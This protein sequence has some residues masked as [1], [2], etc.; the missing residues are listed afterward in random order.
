MRVAPEIFNVAVGGALFEGDKTN[1]K[2]L[3]AS[4]VESVSSSCVSS[5]IHRS[6]EAEHLVSESELNRLESGKVGR[7]DLR[8]YPKSHE[9]YDL[10]K[11]SVAPDVKPKPSEKAAKKYN[12]LTVGL[13]DKVNVESRLEL[14]RTS[15][16]LGGVP[17]FIDAFFKGEPGGR[18]EGY[19]CRP[20]QFCTTS[21]DPKLGGFIISP[22]QSNIP[23]R[24]KSYTDNAS[25]LLERTRGGAGFG[26]V[27][28]WVPPC[29][30]ERYPTFQS[31]FP[32]TAI[33]EN[34]PAIESPV[35]V[36]SNRQDR[37]ASQE[38]NELYKKRSGVDFLSVP[39][40]LRSE[41]APLLKELK[42]KALGHLQQ[43]YGCDGSKDNVEIYTHG[44]FYL[45][46]S[47]G[48]HV[49]IR[50]NVPQHALE[51]DLRIF[52]VD[53]V[54]KQLEGTDGGVTDF[55]SIVSGGYVEFAVDELKKN[56]VFFREVPNVWATPAS[57][58]DSRKRF[59]AASGNFDRDDGRVKTSPKSAKKYDAEEIALISLQGL[60]ERV[61]RYGDGN[62]LPDFVHEFLTS[63]ENKKA[64]A[65]MQHPEQFAA[66]TFSEE[67]GG[68]FI[69]PNSK[70]VPG[71]SEVF[72]DPSSIKEA[73]RSSGG[74]ALVG[75]WVPP[76]VYEG[77]LVFDKLFN[78]N[79]SADSDGVV[80]RETI[81]EYKARTELTYIT[82]AVDV[83]KEH[84]SM[85]EEFKAVAISHLRDTYNVVE[86]LEK[87]DFY[88]HS[89]VYGSKTAGLHIHV[90][91]NQLLP[92]G[93]SDTNA[94]RLDALTSIL[95]DEH[96]LNA[97]VPM[98]ILDAIPKTNS[99][100]YTLYSPVWGKKQFDG[101]DV[102]FVANP[103]RRPQ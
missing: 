60:K 103:W 43:V 52:H 102:D 73:T 62:V 27:A 69:M 64:Q 50:V 45:K 87:V 75:Y 93:E 63:P 32:N 100:K 25:T 17:G 96:V 15:A 72:S 41:H 29:T 56:N 40:N 8:V 80:D 20:E 67:T 94:L 13:V 24:G 38:S 95:K 26:L 30:Y 91:V 2:S 76:K 88:L 92:A 97:D 21:F 49:H 22:N 101:I 58:Q 5:N 66:T 39:L 34:A 83:G 19:L 79:G 6:W 16:S 54:I 42:E 46:N 53:D 11:L 82:N 65:F 44:P 9:C 36:P 14:Y 37:Y 74:F 1:V 47:C 48:F 99:G 4:K 12:N 28:Y 70:H 89:P 55:S 71:K 84:L 85:L 90:R 51:T 77:A 57:E 81:N 68:I 23:E 31:L 86:G 35:F 61:E 3:L 98:K 33:P 10:A 7:T 18:T 59:A 78:V